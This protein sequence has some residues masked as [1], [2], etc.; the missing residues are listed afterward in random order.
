MEP[1]KAFLDYRDT[2]ILSELAQV[3]LQGSHNKPVKRGSTDPI[4]CFEYHVN[5]MGTYN[6]E[7]GYTRK[8]KIIKGAHKGL[9]WPTMKAGSRNQAED[10]SMMIILDSAAEVSLVKHPSLLPQ[11]R[12]RPLH[13]SSFM[14][15][16]TV[17]NTTGT[18]TGMVITHDGKKTECPLGYGGVMPDH[19][20][21][22]NLASV[23]FMRRLGYQFWFGN[24]PYMVTPNGCEVPL[25]IKG[26]G[27]LGL[28]I[29]PMKADEVTKL[30]EINQESY[31]KRICMLDLPPYT[32]RM[33]RRPAQIVYLAKNFNL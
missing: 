18:I 17:C 32:Y 21:K 16:R 26:N 23:P 3:N 9:P 10:G 29:H 19:G 12:N 8:S 31:R 11:P 7:V 24:Y 15:Q 13:L 1:I 20:M 5:T 6:M 14:S 30:Q 4:N 22:D 25:Y 28:R 2:K 33:K 27:Y